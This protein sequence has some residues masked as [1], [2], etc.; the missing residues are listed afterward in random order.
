M[1]KCLPSTF[2]ESHYYLLKDKAPIHVRNGTGTS[3]DSS[4]SQSAEPG[5]K[6][7]PPFKPTGNFVNNARPDRKFGAP[8]LQRVPNADDFP[9]LGGSVPSSRASSNGTTTPRYSGPTAA[10]VLQAPAPR[11]EGQT[12]GN[13]PDLSPSAS[14][15]K[16]CSSTISLHRK[17]LPLRRI[18]SRRSTV[19]C[20]TNL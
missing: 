11:K 17:N 12:R 14:A 3:A 6:G 8:K 4:R 10:Q 2:T 18:A 15:P 1:L 5:Q 19:F 20:P 16:V 7:R 13:T 9:V